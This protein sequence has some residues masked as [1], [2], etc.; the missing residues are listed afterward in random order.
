MIDEPF[1][2]G[3]AFIHRLD[4]R[5]RVVAAIFMSM[6]TALLKDFRAMGVSLTVALFL[7]FL[8][9]LDFLQVMKRLLSLIRFLVFV[10]LLIPLT[11]EG[12]ALYSMAPLNWSREG[13]LLSLQ[14]SLKSLAI[15]LLFMALVATMR[16][17][18]L[19]KALKA[20]Y[21]PGKLVHLLLMTY[22]YIFVIGQ[23]YARLETA[24]KIRGFKPAT[25]LHAYKTYA[26]LVAM[27]FVKASM[28]AERVHQAMVLRG[29]QGRFHSLDTFTPSYRNWF[30]MGGVT[31][32]LTG[33]LLLEGGAS[34]P[35]ILRF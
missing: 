22:R 27:L 35:M 20:L 21:V 13:T 10:W 23:E 15:L 24:I 30:F 1:A 5:F 31:V 9:R 4:P 17:P 28:R 14:I 6:A 16:L 2:S 19:G 26:Y 3:D 18:T 25:T 7:V 29:F 12:H 8:A 33:I 11:Y 32:L 34:W